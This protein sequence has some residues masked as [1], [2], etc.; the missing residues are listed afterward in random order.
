MADT[1]TYAKILYSHFFIEHVKS[2]HKS[3]T[4]PLDLAT[5]RLGEHLYEF[6]PR[7]L[8]CDYKSVRTYETQRLSKQ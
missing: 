1:L 5:L 6:F 8:I 4:T 3:A 7:M 2:H